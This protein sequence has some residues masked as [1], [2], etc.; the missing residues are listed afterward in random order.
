MKVLS[1]SLIVRCS[2]EGPQDRLALEPPCSHP[3]GRISASS[4]E[5]TIVPTGFQVSPA[6]SLVG[7]P[8]EQVC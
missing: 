4:A 8:P 6:T 2:W 1:G 7:T 3:A 5:S